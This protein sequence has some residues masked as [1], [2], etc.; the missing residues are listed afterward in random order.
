MT[1]DKPTLLNF[2]CQFPVKVMG[3]ATD[4]FEAAVYA[5][6]NQ[7]VDKLAEDAIKSRTSKNGNYLSLTI[8]IEATSQQQL[9]ALY[10]ALSNHEL[11]LVAL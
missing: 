8:T 10:Q 5:I 4:A 9:D 1:D 6:I 11:V 7:H 3:A 2:P